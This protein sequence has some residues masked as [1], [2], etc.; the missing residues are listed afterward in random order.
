MCHHGIITMNK[1]TA[2]VALLTSLLFFASCSSRGDLNLGSHGPTVDERGFQVVLLGYKESPERIFARLMFRNTTDRDVS[3]HTTITKDKPLWLVA[4][5]ESQQVPATAS[6]E[7]FD[8]TAEEQ[9]W[10]L[11][12]L[13]DTLTVRAHSFEIIESGF[14]FSPSLSSKNVA[15]SLALVG[16]WSFGD[17]L[18]VTLSIPAEIPNETVFA[19]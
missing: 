12:K 13:T 3:F 16:Q 9:F 4:T 17:I 7:V 6:Q 5:A 2:T 10:T 18:K 1:T 8:P 14:P 19:R 15:W 11:E